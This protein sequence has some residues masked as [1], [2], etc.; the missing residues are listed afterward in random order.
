VRKIASTYKTPRDGKQGV[1][2]A[3]SEMAEKQA[4]H[5]GDAAALTE[6][7]ETVFAPVEGSKD[8]N[9]DPGWKLVQSS[10]L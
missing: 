10:G 7:V 8:S 1:F 6:L 2:R 4:L 3:M 9:T 5:P